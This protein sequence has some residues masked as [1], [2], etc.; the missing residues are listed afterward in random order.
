MATANIEF[1]PSGSAPNGYRV[2]YR[3]IGTTGSYTTVS[4]NPSTSPAVISSFS[5]VGIEGDISA[6]CGSGLY[7]A[8]ANFS[9]MTPVNC[10]ETTS[11]VYVG[12]GSY[13]YENN[14][15]RLNLF[16]WSSPNVIRLTFDVTSAYVPTS[17]E[18]RPA[19]FLQY[20]NGSL[21][22]T[23]NY[24]G[25]MS[26][27]G[28]WGANLDNV[29]PKYYTLTPTVYTSAAG[30]TNSGTTI[31]VGST[32]GLVAGMTVKV[33]SGT[34]VFPED[35]RVASVTNSTTFVVTKA[36]TTNLSASAVVK[37]ITTYEYLIQVAEALS[38]NPSNCSWSLSLN[39][40]YSAPANCSTA[41][42]GTTYYALRICPSTNTTNYYTTTSGLSSGSRV[43]YA[44]TNYV[45]NPAYNVITTPYTITGT[46]SSSN[47][48][49]V[50]TTTNLTVG[51]EVTKTAGT[52][53]LQSGTVITAITS[54]TT[55]TV[56]YVPTVALSSATIVCQSPVPANLLG[57]VTPTGLY[58][59]P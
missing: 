14:K 34:G 11:D 2:R 49:T 20:V 37:A 47:V 13:S 41:G 36:P 55:F 21:A 52:G 27:S 45:H 18:T 1:T 43:T 44:G 48:I 24:V 35:T 33:T 12:T 28:S 3:K 4:P 40:N 51:M 19:R 7:S 15:I 54:S 42:S 58:G 10:T 9:A 31:T 39:C 5:T 6:D 8:V 22:F 59:C 26:S 46:S 32:T 25:K 30:A 29:G 23:E 17:T 53:T 38:G 50:C 56:N 16:N 57:A